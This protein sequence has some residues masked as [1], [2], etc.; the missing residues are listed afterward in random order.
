MVFT[1]FDLVAYADGILTIQLS[2]ATA[3][4]GWAAEFTVS[5]RFDGISGYIRK[6][7]AS[8]YGGGQSGITILDSG[9]GRFNI[10]IWGPDGSGLMDPG[11]YAM[12][13]T[14]TDSGL[15][16]PLAKGWFLRLP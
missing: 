2:P 15:N 3:V 14:R 16:T 10:R 1:G 5:K 6:T 12:Q 9:A 11:T 8:G 7:V 13:F 4:G